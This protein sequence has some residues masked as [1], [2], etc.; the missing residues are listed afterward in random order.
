[1]K[2][3][4]DATVTVDGGVVKASGDYDGGGGTTCKERIQNI[5]S[6]LDCT[7]S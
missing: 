5:Y 1:L 4:Y 3:V 6:G 7:I 2:R